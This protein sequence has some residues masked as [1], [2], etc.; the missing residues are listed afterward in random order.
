MLGSRCYQAPAPSLSYS[1]SSLSLS[2]PGS[3]K[4]LRLTR[5][6]T[7]TKH[8]PSS[9][10]CSCHRLHLINN[11]Q[12]CRSRS[13]STAWDSLEQQEKLE[14]E[15]LELPACWPV[16]GAKFFGH[17]CCDGCVVS[18]CKRGPSALIFKR[19]LLC[20]NAKLGGVSGY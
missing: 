14:E 3:I 19:T 17:F 4:L 20:I 1:L 10:S 7:T 6:T 2:R 18:S 15:L 12:N 8:T 13:W 9:S 5:A 11:S 16:V